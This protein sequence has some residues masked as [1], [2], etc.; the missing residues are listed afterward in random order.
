MN[1]PL[2]SMTNMLLLIIAVVL[3]L[4]LLTLVGIE[5]ELR[6]M[7]EREFPKPRKRNHYLLWKPGDLA[8]YDNGKRVD[9]WI[10][11]N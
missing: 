9:R 11:S 8:F 7:N 1:A 10:D 4:I 6:E 2:L 3:T 5:R